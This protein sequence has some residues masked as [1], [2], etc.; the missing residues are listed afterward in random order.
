VHLY[1][2]APIALIKC[3]QHICVSPL[4][5]VLPIE[6]EHSHIHSGLEFKLSIYQKNIKKKRRRKIIIRVL[7]IANCF[8]MHIVLQFTLLLVI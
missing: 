1:I 6:S 4:L 3:S 5:I 7:G 8:P 2:Q